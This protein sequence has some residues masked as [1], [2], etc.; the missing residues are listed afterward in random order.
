MPPGGQSTHNLSFWFRKRS[1]LTRAG[2]AAAGLSFDPRLAYSAYSGWSRV[3]RGPV[4]QPTVGSEDSPLDP[5]Y[6]DLLLNTSDLEALRR[7]T[8]TV[9]PRG[10]VYSLLRHAMLLAY[11]TAATRLQT[12]ASGVPGPP[13]FDREFF[14]D[15]NT[16]WAALNGPA[17]GVTD[18]PLWAYLRELQSTPADAVIAAC[19]SP[20]LELRESLAHLKTLS[21]A[22]LAAALR[23]HDRPLLASP[24]RLGD[25]V[26]DET[27][28]R[29]ARSA[30]H[31]H[32]ARRLRVGR[33]PQTVA[34]A[35]R[36]NAARR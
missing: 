23:R 17:A 18:R 19:V 7:E 35:R 1:E 27:P 5:N 34:A 16:A 11:W 25:V 24:R 36:G 4:A 21:A 26:R 20:L 22:K 28:R 8:F 31:R 3:L 15:P 30:R 2:L 9:Q 12:A 32:R 14:D 33:E 13:P 6:I 10:L 29:T